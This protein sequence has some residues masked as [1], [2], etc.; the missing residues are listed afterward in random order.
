MGARTGRA[1]ASATGGQATADDGSGCAKLSV[2]L[3]A[4]TDKAH[5]VTSFSTPVDLSRATIS[6]RY[7]VQ[8][9]TG[10]V[11]FNY[12]QDTSDR[13]LGASMRP[14]IN[15]GTG[16]W[17]TLTWDVGTEAPA[18]TGVTKTAIKRIGIEVNG[19]GSS[20]WTN[21]TII[22]VD[23]ITVTTPARSFTFDTTS[24]VSTM[25][26]STDIASQALWLNSNSSDTTAARSTL[27]WSATCP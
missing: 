19:S 3:N 16:T 26:A 24:S 22:F 4:A 1:G 20:A 18:M 17:S 21:P 9:G 12:V 8:A 5:F 7:Y 2:P 6:M 14:A 15:L 11:I 27:A 10:G 13:F 25:A 23:S